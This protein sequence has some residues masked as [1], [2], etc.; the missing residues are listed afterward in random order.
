MN[1]ASATTGPAVPPVASGSTPVLGHALRLLRD[2]LGF[3]ESLRQDGDVVRVKAGPKTIYAI[4]APGLVELLLLRHGP[5]LVIGGPFWETLEDILGKG[6]ATSNGAAHRRQ[7]RIIQPL[8]RPDRVSEYT[9]VMTEEAQAMA[10]RWEP[11]QVVDIAAELFTTV[12]RIVS[13]SLLDVPS[14][15]R[16][17]DEIGIA[18]HTVF[19]GMYRRMVLPAKVLYRVPTRS[20]RRFDR[21][22]A[23]L[24]RITDEIIAE[25]R[26]SGQDHDDLLGTLLAARDEQGRPLPE[27]E[28]HDNIL[29][30]I[31]GGSET[32]ASTLSWTFWLLSEHPEL[33]KRL[34]EEA[35][36]EVATPGPINPSA[37]SYTRDLVYEAMRIRPA[38][39]I[40]TRRATADIELDGHRIPAGS[41]IVYSTYALQ[42]DGRSFDRPLEFDPSRWHPDRAAPASKAAMMPFGIGNRKC[43]GDHFSVAETAIIVAAVTSRWRLRPVAATDASTRIDITLHPARLLLKAEPRSYSS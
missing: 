36:A 7:R 22:L 42:R 2:P 1:P 20:N 29:S 6:V 30:I 37:I 39:W 43:P 34:H 16:R 32:V 8:F 17:A 28:I 38:A 26:G 4:T 9:A 3:V 33:E 40:F 19:A 10:E 27:T 5:S 41:D 18:L 31:V 11:G 15:G 13:R 21:A 14:I 24:H 35:D 23:T 12:V 25:R